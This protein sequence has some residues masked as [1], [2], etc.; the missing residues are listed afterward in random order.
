MPESERDKFFVLKVPIKPHLRLF[1]DHHYGTEYVVSHNNHIGLL[2]YEILRK[3]QFRSEKYYKSID[4][5]DDQWKVKISDWYTFNT[6]CMLI[7][8]YQ[9]HLINSYLESLLMD[10]CHIYLDARQVDGSADIKSCIYDFIDRYDL[11]SGSKDWYSKIKQSYRRYREKI[12]ENIK[13]SSRRLSP[14][15]KHRNTTFMPCSRI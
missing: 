15:I 5:Y 4:E 10:N 9:V 11:T 8:H 13:K 3:R 14:E 6:S 12:N 7:N 2:I 1:I